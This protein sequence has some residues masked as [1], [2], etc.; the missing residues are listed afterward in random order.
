MAFR[1]SLLP[2][3]PGALSKLNF[4]MLLLAINPKIK[5]GQGIRGIAIHWARTLSFVVW[6]AGFTPAQGADTEPTT[7]DEDG[8]RFFEN[9]IRPLL[10]THCQECHG[11]KKQQGGLRLD[12]H[13]AVLRGGDTGAAIVPGDA[14]ASLLIDAVRY[15]QLYK[16]PPRGKLPEASIALLAEWVSRGAP[17]GT[18]V[19][20]A[21]P[22]AGDSSSDSERPITDEDRSFWAFRPPVEP[23]L[24]PRERESDSDAPIDRFI[25]AE[26]KKA[27]IEPATPADKR[28]LIRRATFDLTGLPPT[29]EEIEQ[30][31]TSDSPDAF[32]DL[33]DR[34][35]ASPR[36]GEHWGR[37]W[38]DVAR[39][40]DSNG[41]DENLAYANAYRYRDYVIDAFNRDKPFDQFLIEQIAGDLLPSA[42]DEKSNFER[43]V[44][45][46]FLCVGA[47]MLAEDDP[48]KMEMDI[49]DE[50]LDTLGMAF[51]G[52][53]L[54]CAR[55][56]DHKFD[57]IPT[58]DYYG[59][60][61]I[62]KSTKTMENFQVV[63][64][65]QE[66]PLASA[67]V[68]RALADYQSRLADAKSKTQAL[69]ESANLAV[70]EEAKARAD[71]YAIGAIQ[72]LEYSDAFPPLST[73]SLAAAQSASAATG[74]PLV[75]EAENYVR[76][77][78]LIDRDN[79][80]PGI[81]VILNKGELPNFAEYEFETAPGYY[82]I[83]T[84]FAAETPRP[85]ELALDGS[86]LRGDLANAATGSWRPDTQTWRPEV[87]TWLDAGRH[88]LRLSCAGPFPHFDKLALIPRGAASGSPPDPARSPDRLAASRNLHLSLLRPWMA[89]FAARPAARTRIAN[90]ISSSA[91]GALSEIGKQVVQ[92]A[93]ADVENPARLPV[94][95]APLY[96]AK[97]ATEISEAKERIQAIEK[98]EHP[99]PPLA[100]A[101]SEGASQD[102]RVHHRGSHLTLG[103]ETPRHFPR[104]LAGENQPSLD[105]S[106][107]GRL[108]LAK[109]MTRADH[110]LTARV[111]VNR[112]WRWHFGAGLVRSTD[113][114][115]RLGERPSHPELLD[116]LAL[117]FVQSGWSMKSLHRTIMLSETY[118]RGS[119]HDER[120]AF[121]D[122]DNRLLWR[123]NRRRLEAEAIR[124]SLL[125]AGGGL[126]TAIGGSLLSTKNRDY[127][128][129]TASVNPTNYESNR[130]AVYLPVV[131][132]A[133]F[134]VFQA[135]DFAEPSVSNGDRATTTVAPQALFMMNSPFVAEQAQRLAAQLLA[136]TEASDASRVT[137]AYAIAFG[138]NPTEAES[139]R[140]LAFLARY[141]E[142]ALAQFPEAPARHQAA[143][144]SLVRSLFS[145]NEFIF[146]D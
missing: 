76:G 127:V 116:W 33:I 20:H 139:A 134:D 138:R 51:L 82:Q 28:T 60:A 114:F 131:R 71:E 10:V 24:P 41:L 14:D 96:S 126:E 3:R 90:E 125:A 17:W 26:L 115:G 123:V 108:E 5:S 8:V 69:V 31:L 106:R 54:G 59:L 81:G 80:G 4:G 104:V 64:R 38:L 85:C 32:A 84:R 50:Q 121:L 34:L 88:V 118:R 42:S 12:S 94:D 91:N 62:F 111:F 142:V 145:A 70:A 23:T 49:I 30:F 22:L 137:R 21:P 47:K 122:P 53:T 72:A 11:E 13:E 65:W 119:N 2:R 43:I 95:P 44:A 68:A 9:K 97:T 107:S 83:E 78:A 52:L 56:H 39:F 74:D 16:M 46:G 25:G 48:V 132:S 27:G 19:E 1:F 110:P 135:F 102:L 120:S 58:S 112:A 100:M 92:E 77:N 133:L 86:L 130:R 6:L 45:T 87:V 144:R 73:E 117:R 15:G 128:A 61:G 124:D 93:L 103:K 55:C 146:V 105:P 98:E 79:Y 18:E 129:G 89:Y 35:L 109:W 36:Y 57:P 101:V 140:A 136:P 29:P 75:I 66:R 113:N 37:H 7:I 143:W 63:A 67:D 99:T 141:D 40:A